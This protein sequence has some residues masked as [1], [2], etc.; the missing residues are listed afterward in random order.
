MNILALNAG[1]TSLKFG[2][3][4]LALEP[5][6]AGSLDWSGG[7]RRGAVFSLRPRH[8]PPETRRVDAGDDATATAVVLEAVA[9]AMRGEPLAAVGHRIVHG[10]AEFS[11]SARVDAA[12]KAAIGRLGALAPLHNPPALRVL[13]AAETALAGVPE[14]AV[15]DTAF[16]ARLPL[17]AIVYPVPF[18]WY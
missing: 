17:S 7:G 4:D 16:F 11:R 18:A 13:E 15:F 9:A 12:V 10:G 2:L 3:F 8:G 5:R 1:S 14:V 6:L